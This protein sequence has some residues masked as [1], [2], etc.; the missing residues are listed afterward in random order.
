MEESFRRQTMTVAYFFDSYAVV[1]IL[2]GSEDYKAYA[3]EPVTLTMFQL[4]EIYWYALLNYKEDA[5]EEIYEKYR[6]AV[7][8]VDDATLKE[9]IQFRK[10]HKKR[11]LSY[12]DCIGYVYA[13][14]HSMKFLTG[15][16][17]FQDLPNVKFVK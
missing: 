7:A 14:R 8:E 17:E 9:A 1:E 13:K 12:A 6:A 3:V 4:A 2:S 11:D 16:K 10:R 15:D 5:A